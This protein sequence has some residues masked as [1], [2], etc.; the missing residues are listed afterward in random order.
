VVSVLRGV[1]GSLPRD[2]T[3]AAV[4]LSSCGPCVV[5]VDPVGNPLRPGI[6]YGVDTRATDQVD[7]LNHLIG[8]GIVR[9]SYGMPLTSQ[10]VGPKLDWLAENEPQVFARTADFLSANGFAAARLTG[11]RCIDHHQAAYFAPYYRDGA[12]DRTYDRSGVVDRLPDLVWSNEVIGQVTDSAAAEAGLQAG[13]PVVIGSSDGL[14]SAYGAGLL[15]GGGG[16]L[17][18][19][20]TLGLTV[21]A[22]ATSPGGAWRTPGGQPDDVCL[23]AGLSTGGVL[24]SWFV[25]RFAADLAGDFGKAHRT[26]A[27]QAADSPPGARGLLLLPYFEGERTPFYDP[28]ATGALLGLR[29]HHSRGDLYR[30]FLEGT[31]FAVRG[32][33]AEVTR[34]GADVG[35]LRAVGGGTRIPLWQ[36]IVSDVCG[37]AQTVTPGDHG[38]ATGAAVLAAASVSPEAA[39]AVRAR[40]AAN[41]QDARLVRP[42]GRLRT[43]YD[44][45]FAVFTDAYPR[46]R[47]AM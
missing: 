27:D 11:R 43:F 9:A 35:E 19:G 20:S 36:Q 29:L 26:L 17:N 16:V 37:L 32:V 34:M 21:L 23:V 10:A 39:V 7:R 22:A 40:I 25:D 5:A 41:W 1:V 2:A 6:L 47:P 15:S 24:L 14:T 46:T 28:E 18:Y 4:G 13:V 45:R 44:Q 3:V 30:A 31:A 42:N 33:L 12:W 8:E 38:A